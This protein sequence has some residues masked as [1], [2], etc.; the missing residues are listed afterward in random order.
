MAERKFDYNE[1]SEAYK[2]MQEITGSSSDPDSIA[3]ILNDMNK[4]MDEKV[5]VEGQAIFGALGSQL[6]LDW[7]NS[8]SNFPTFVEKFGD[9]SALVAKSGSNYADFEADFAGFKENIDTYRESNPLGTTSAGISTNYVSL[10]PY[11]EYNAANNPNA[12]PKPG[13]INSPDG[14]DAPSEETAGI[15]DGDASTPA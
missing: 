3:G 6:K 12:V 7:E 4:A 2:K 13:E 11:T 8:T 15:V 1:V 9:W 14:A 10:T 5:A